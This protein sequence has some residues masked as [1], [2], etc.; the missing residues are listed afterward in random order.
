MAEVTS[1][2]NETLENCNMNLES[3]AKVT[4]IMEQLKKDADE[5]IS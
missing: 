2:A 1:N 3:V 4:E 5:M